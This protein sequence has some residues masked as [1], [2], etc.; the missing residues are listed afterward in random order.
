MTLVVNIVKNKEVSQWCEYKDAE[1]KILAEFKIRGIAHKAYQV[2]LERANNQVSSKGFDVSQASSQD[3][4]FHELLFQAAACHLIEDWK[5]ISFRVN[6][7]EAE[8]PCTPENACKLLEMGDIG[9]VIFAF[10]R[11]KAEQIQTEA[12]KYRDEVLGKSESSMNTA[13]SS[14]D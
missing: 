6:G 14:Q 8:Q 5:G 4:T 9:P 12:D 7:E 10:V 2:S 3:K 13:V 11:V 1:G